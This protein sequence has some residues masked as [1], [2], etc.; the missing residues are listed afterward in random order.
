M[1]F[2]DDVYLMGA[3]GGGKLDVLPQVPHFIDAPV[4]CPVDFNDV[5]AR[6]LTDG[7]AIVAKATWLWSGSFLAVEAFG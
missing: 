1:D 3:L 5:N 6:A 7:P 4:R 2:V